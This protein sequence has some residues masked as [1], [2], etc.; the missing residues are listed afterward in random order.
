[1]KKYRQRIRPGIF[2]VASMHPNGRVHDFVKGWGTISPSGKTILWDSWTKPKKS[3]RVS[4]KKLMENFS[5]VFQT[6]PIKNMLPVPVLT[7]IM[8]VQPMRLPDDKTP[9]A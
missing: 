1:M 4:I 9:N 8:S 3:K 6:P 2:F 7:D 5:S